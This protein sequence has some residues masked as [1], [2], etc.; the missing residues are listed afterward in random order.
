MRVVDEDVHDKFWRIIV[1]NAH[2]LSRKT[3]E[4]AIASLVASLPR[5]SM[6]DL[7]DRSLRQRS[8]YSLVVLLDRAGFGEPRDG[9]IRSEADV[10]EI[11][12]RILGSGKP[13][14]APTLIQQLA[15]PKRG[16]L[17]W[18]DLMLFRLTCCA[19]RLGQVHNIY[20]A[21]VQY[22]DP[23][24]RAVGDVGAITQTSMRRF[25]QQVFQE[26]RKSY[27][28]AELSFFSQVD[29]VSD[30]AILGEL[31]TAEIDGADVGRDLNAAR[32]AI[33]T[34][35][36]YQLM[37]PLRA[38]GSGIGCG[39]YDETGSEDGGGIYR[40][41]CKYLLEYCFNPAFG[42]SH[43][44][45]FADYCLR[46]FRDEIRMHFGDLDIPGAQVVLTKLVGREEMKAFWASSGP[47]IKTMLANE[48]GTVVSYQYEA[49]YA[50]RLPLV[51]AA[52][53]QLVG[54]DVVAPD[55]SKPLEPAA[56]PPE[57]L[58]A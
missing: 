55:G 33:K 51:F 17:G 34:F 41:M 16:P 11:A 9:R 52:L 37:N 39:V 28:D 47:Q 36:I 43:A 15:A 31:R 21:L 54:Y 42:I 1:N 23:S 13:E 45:A 57:D 4:D 38:N 24:A 50:E 18:E 26:F 35:V 19:D 7:G 6:M 32:S 29:E 46:A 22:E 40:A 49:T 14:S 53:D 12:Q 25:S 5:Y 10:I 27:I 44:R 3:A 48:S 30:A 20:T 8:I 56:D 2:G 58:T